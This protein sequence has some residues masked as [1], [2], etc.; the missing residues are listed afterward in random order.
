M[1]FVLVPLLLN[2][3][4]RSTLNAKAL[5]KGYFTLYD[6]NDPFLDTVLF[7]P[8]LISIVTYYV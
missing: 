5:P 6:I 2:K 3:S 8:K 7:P 1:K 4:L